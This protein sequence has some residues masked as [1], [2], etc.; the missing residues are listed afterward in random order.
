MQYTHEI[1]LR[2]RDVIKTATLRQQGYITLWTGNGAI[3][4]GL[5]AGAVLRAVD[6]ITEEVANG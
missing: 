3:H 4:L 5:P 6:A 2:G 1:T